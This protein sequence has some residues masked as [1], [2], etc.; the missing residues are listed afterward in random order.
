MSWTAIVPFK[1]SGERKSR[2]AAEL[3]SDERAALSI[4]MFRHVVDVLER[5]PKVARTIILSN[6][7]PADWSGAWAQDNG[8][9]LN[10]ELER[11]RADIGGDVLILHADLP[12]LQNED[13]DALVDAAQEDSIAI[14]PDRHGSGTNGLALKAGSTL[15]FQF[16]PDSFHLHR[17]QAPT[18]PVV[19]RDGFGFDLDTP[20]DLRAL[21]A[22]GWLSS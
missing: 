20:D 15:N 9:G 7:R 22:V 8:G 18:C 17:N 11:V 19:H 2:L 4:R 3:S 12:L 14:A 16:G 5:H 6:E 10:P 21:R 13:I 1:A